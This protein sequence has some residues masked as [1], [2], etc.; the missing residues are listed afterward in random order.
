VT[1]C[2]IV[3]ASRAESVEVL[4]TGNNFDGPI[5]PTHH[6]LAACLSDPAR[7]PAV[8]F[9]KR[10]MLSGVARC[11]TCGQLLYAVYPGGMKRGII[12]VCR[13]SSH[14]ARTGALMD[15]YVAALVLAWFSQPKTRKR[16]SGLLDGGRDVDV[17][18]LQAQRD[19][20]QPVVG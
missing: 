16:L 9:D 3:V 10:H 7:R 20:L 8:S 18:A 19:A 11:G 4:G 15:E 12:Y 1:W 6:G 17:K 14:V 2:I 5:W 13:P